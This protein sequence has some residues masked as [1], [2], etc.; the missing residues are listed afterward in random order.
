MDWEALASDGQGRLYV[1]DIGNNTVRG[2]LPL[3]LVYQVPEP[4][5][6]P[7][8]GPTA[9]QPA[10]RTLPVQ[11]VITYSFPD[12]R[13]DAEAMFCRQGRLYVVSKVRTG[14]TG[15]WEVALDGPGIARPVR[16]VCSLPK[17]HTVTDA[18]LSPDG[19]R[20]ALCSYEYTAIF[21]LDP[22]EP[23]ENLQHRQPLI[24]GHVPPL[25]PPT[26]IEACCWIG[27][28]T[29]L[30]G[31]EGGPL[32]QLAVPAASSPSAG[33]ALAPTP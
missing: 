19:R 6:A 11:A 31:A 26:S 23:L 33:R 29:L 15:L 18:S 3:R 24:V 30:L 32:Y 17:V 1:G 16:Q 27:P 20:L 9:T 28:A 2:G 5:V 12:V 4:D 7:L 22:A 13:F 25:K 10:R 8:P 21:P 14:R